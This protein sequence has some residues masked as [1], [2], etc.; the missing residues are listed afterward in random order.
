MMMGM[1][2]HVVRLTRRV[3]QM[4]VAEVVMDVRVMVQ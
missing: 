1:F 3:R 4:A 2:G